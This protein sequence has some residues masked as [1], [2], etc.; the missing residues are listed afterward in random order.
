MTWCYLEQAGRGN[1]AEDGYV[2]LLGDSFTWGY[3]PLEQTWGTSLEQFI[4]ARVLKCGVSGYGARNEPEKLNA[5]VTRAGRPAFV[6]V[7]HVMK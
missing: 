5:V 7:G 3:V 4:G 6:I 1:H 2:L